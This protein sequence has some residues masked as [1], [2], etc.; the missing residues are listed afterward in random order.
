MAFLD[1]ACFYGNVMGVGVRGYYFG[2]DA[3]VAAFCIAGAASAA[4][5][6]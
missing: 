4:G 5:F 2:C 1:V 6:A 3:C